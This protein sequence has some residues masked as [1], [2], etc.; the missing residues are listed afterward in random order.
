MRVLRP[1]RDETDTLARVPDP[2]Q[3]C[4]IAFCG[5]KAEVLLPPSKSITLARRRLEL[6][7]CGGGSPL[8]HAL[9]VAI[10][11]GLQVRAL[12]GR[13]RSNRGLR[14]PHQ[15]VRPVVGALAAT[16]LFQARQV[17]DV[18][19]VMV[20]LITDGRAN[21]SLAR[22]NGDPDAL[23]PDAPRPSN[24]GLRVSVCMRACALAYW[25]KVLTRCPEVRSATPP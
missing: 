4:L 11:T 9:S 23:K 15:T 3:V 14:L 21:I 22:S 19:R 2:P 5:D 10:R 18:G 25:V 16:L 20:I 24:E 7:P 1:V 17:G 8:A 12:W 13:S 6:L